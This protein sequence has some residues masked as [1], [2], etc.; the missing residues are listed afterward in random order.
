MARAGAPRDARQS[1]GRPGTA[2]SPSRGSLTVVGIGFV[3]VRHATAETVQTIS[4]ADHVFYL[5]THAAAVRWIE[6]LNPHTTPLGTFLR[7]GKN[8]GRSYREM[9]S[10]VVAAV[11]RGERV[12]AVFYGHPGVLVAAGRDAIRRAQREGYRARMLPAISAED[13][14]FADLPI[15]PR[16]QSWQCFEATDLLLRR[17]RFDPTVP[18]ILWQVGVLG[19]ASV[20]PHHQ[21]RPERLA[22]LTD[23]LRRHYPANHRIVLYEAAEFP[24]CDPVIDRVALRSLPRRA[25]FP[26]TTLYVPPLATTVQDLRVAGWLTSA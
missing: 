17:R 1:P 10:A 3:L 16:P 11:R 2:G 6:R 20:R 9:A 23:V 7:V 4:D 24:L 15:H 25:V 12:C 5:L 8:R 18:L 14:L 19:E 26:K 13:C 22:R 21:A